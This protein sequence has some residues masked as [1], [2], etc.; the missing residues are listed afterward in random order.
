MMLAV[1]LLSLKLFGTPYAFCIEAVPYV[2]RAAVLLNKVLHGGGLPDETREPSLRW[3]LL[4]YALRNFQ[5]VQRALICGLEN[6]SFI[7]A[8]ARFGLYC[9]RADF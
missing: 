1:K 7:R 9:S 5:F 3:V 4:D 6:N 2:R 8:F